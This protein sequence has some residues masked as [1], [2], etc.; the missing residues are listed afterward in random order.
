LKKNRQ[1]NVQ[2]HKD[3]KCSTKKTLHRKLKME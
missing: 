2:M 1:Y 3:K